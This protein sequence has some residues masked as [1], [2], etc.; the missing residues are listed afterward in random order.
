MN[1]SSYKKKIVFLLISY[2]EWKKAMK[3]IKFEK[4]I[5]INTLIEKE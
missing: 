5:K 4:K 3:E 1:Y 2:M